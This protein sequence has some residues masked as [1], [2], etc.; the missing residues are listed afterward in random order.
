MTDPTKVYRQVQVSTAAQDD[1]LML[2]LDGGVRFCEGA[3]IELK[4]GPKHDIDR[5]NDH[6]L[7]AQKIILELMGALSPAIGLE[8]YERLMDLYRFTFERLFEGNVE[9]SVEKVEEGTRVMHRIRDLWREAVDKA[10]AE[11]THGPPKATSNSSI[12]VK[13]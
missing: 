6:L 12:S 5:R 2:L 11:R 7:R 13:G 1:L 4:K 8:L 9:S 10:K 3:L